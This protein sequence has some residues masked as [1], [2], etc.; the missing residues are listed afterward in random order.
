MATDRNLTRLAR[1]AEDCASG[2]L[3]FKDSLPNRSTHITAIL[4]ELFAISTALQQLGQAHGDHVFQP[5]WFRIRNNLALVVPALELTF[6]AIFDSFGRVRTLSYA[7]V[8]TDLE[9]RMERE[10]GMVLVERLEMFRTFVLALMGVLE[11]SPNP[12][13]MVLQ[14][15][16]V[17]LLDRQEDY[18]S[19]TQRRAIRD[20]RR[21]LFF[22]PV[23]GG[24]D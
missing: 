19:R 15:D 11:G 10:E 9:Y 3:P 5:S 8:W 2:L 12:N 17:R 4:S 14:D 21:L 18:E 16:I 6:K 23:R 22:L 20:S 1:D 7:R 13:L 24:I